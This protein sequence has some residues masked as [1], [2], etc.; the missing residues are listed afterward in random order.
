MTREELV[1]FD[2]P[3]AP[4]VYLFLGSPKRSGGGKGTRNKILYVGKATSLRDRV[5]SYFASDLHEKRSPLVAKM[6]A[7]AVSIDWIETGSVLEALILEAS[8]IKKHQPPG[9]TIEKDNKSYNYVIITKELFPRVLIVRGRVLFDV[10]T[11][12]EYVPKSIFGPF[13]HGSQLREAMILIRKIFPYRDTCT[14]ATEKSHRPCFNRQI[15]L[16]PGVCSGEVSSRE[17]ARTIKNITELF[18]G[19]F[20]GLVRRLTVEMQTAANEER[21]EYAHTLKRQIDALTH[22]R[23]VALIKREH[24]TSDG[25][26]SHMRIECYD[27]AHTGGSETVGVM[28]VIQGGEPLKSAYRIFNIQT[29]TNDD[30]ASLTEILTRRMTHT[31]WPLPGLI[32]VD[33]SHAQML[34]AQRVLRDAKHMIPLVG[35][36]K[37]AHHKPDHFV[38]DSAMIERFEKDI[39]LGNAEAHRFAITHHRTRM[40]KR[41][42]S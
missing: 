11:K 1:Q 28:T 16:C 27:V 34:A 25:G 22:V 30:T 35:V 21:F 24:S 23:D 8:L 29:A 42:L 32:V 2:L 37:D 19:N 36:V 9:N 12:K 18:S 20:K 38:G 39:L 31:E 33:G 7:D 26:T 40:R 41:L 15:G 5:R 17:Y 4:G 6:V 10:N 14:P 13:P 3:D